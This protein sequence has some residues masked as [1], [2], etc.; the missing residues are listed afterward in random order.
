MVMGLTV[1]LPLGGRFCGPSSLPI[2]TTCVAFCVVQD[3]TLGLPAAVVV[4][5][6]AVNDVILTVPTFTVALAWIVPVAL[7]AVSV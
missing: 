2:S 3:R 4:T 1:K 5:G 7:V 6:L